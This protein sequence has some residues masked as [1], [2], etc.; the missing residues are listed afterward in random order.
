MC[1]VLNGELALIVKNKSVTLCGI[2]RVLDAMDS[3]SDVSE[4]AHSEPAPRVTGDNN[5]GT[6]HPI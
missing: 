2:V 1:K 5:T 3:S 4:V 6:W